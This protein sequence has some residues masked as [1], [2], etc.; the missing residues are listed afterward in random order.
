MLLVCTKIPGFIN[1]YIKSAFHKYNTSHK[2]K[3]R[4][5]PPAY[6][7]PGSFDQPMCDCSH[8]N[9]I[10]N[11]FQKLSIGK[12]CKTY[13]TYHSPKVS[14]NTIIRDAKVAEAISAAGKTSPEA[15][16]EILSGAAGITRKQLNELLTGSEDDVVEIAA[17]IEDGTFESRKTVAQTP[18][19]KVK[20]IGQSGA[21]QPLSVV[22]N[23]MADRFNMG[24]QELSGNYDSAELKE[25]LR[26]HIDR[27]EDIFRQM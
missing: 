21:A 24:L 4:G 13:L 7:G 10:I 3:R 23:A 8:G 5:E 14:R 1:R 25:M 27:L 15:K 20:D 26:L 2:E 18:N 9:Y 17:K 12:Y 22:F 16:R 6:G 11:E 19:E